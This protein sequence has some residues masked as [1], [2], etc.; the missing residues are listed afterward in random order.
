[1]KLRILY[2]ELL[3]RFS[4]VEVVGAAERVK[5]NFVLGYETLPVRVHAH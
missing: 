5:S 3:R 1:M 4:F 2:E